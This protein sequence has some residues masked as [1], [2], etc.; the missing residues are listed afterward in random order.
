M[1]WFLLIGLFLSINKSMGCTTP[2]FANITVQTNFSLHHFLGIWYEMKWFSEEPHN[3][4]DLWRDYSQSFQLANNSNQQ[5]L[6][7]GKA[8]LLNEDKCFSFGPWLIIANN[9]A[10][11]VLEKKNLNDSTYLNW[12]YYILKTDYDHYALIYACMTDNYTLNNSCDEPVV[13]IFSRTIVLSNQYLHELDGYIENNLCINSTDFEI[14]FHR[15][16]SCYTVASLG[17]KIGSMNE[18]FFVILTYFVFICDI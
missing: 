10:K 17:L 12:P 7:S 4:S 3:E 1:Y 2:T 18:I 16:K 14:T 9:S 13:W 6:V 5:L 11:M 8:R 15:E